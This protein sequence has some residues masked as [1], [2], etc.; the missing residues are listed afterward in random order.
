MDL[1][2][3]YPPEPYG[4][5]PAVPGFVLTS[6]DVADGRP[7]DIRHSVDGANVSPALAWSGF[8][9]ATRY[10]ALSCFD[11]DAPTP[12]GFWHWTV[13]NLPASL[14]SVPRGFGTA[15]GTLPAGA[16][17]ARNDAG[18]LAYAGAAPPPGD[19]PHRY[20]FAVHAL[21]APIEVPDGVGCTPAAFMSLFHTIARATLAPTYAR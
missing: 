13:L 19:H 1:T 8:P 21:D 4:L 17:R 15:D 12:A 2:R 6:A 5:L 14:T 16:V 11:P 9:S 3:P 18:T 10:F 20:I 7:M